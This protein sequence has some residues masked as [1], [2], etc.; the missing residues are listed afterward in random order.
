MCALNKRLRKRLLAK[1]SKRLLLAVVT[2]T[3]LTI[4]PAG[5]GISSSGPPCPAPAIR[6]Y[7]AADREAL[8][9]WI[10]TFGGKAEHAAAYKAVR[11][12]RI[13]RIQIKA[14]GE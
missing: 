13:L 12:Y 9:V 6:P 14:C 1:H 7:L 10:E 4:W 8:A 11:E 2:L 3:I 5:C